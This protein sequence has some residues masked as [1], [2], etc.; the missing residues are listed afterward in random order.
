MS[1]IE[2]VEDGYVDVNVTNPN[3]EGGQTKQLDVYIVGHAAA[4][5]IRQYEA[6]GRPAGKWSEQAKELLAKYG[7]NVSA[8]TA[9]EICY[10]LINM[11][12]DQTKKSEATPQQE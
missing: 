1:C 12:G 4:A 3:G 11:L 2:V 8:K 6:E 9:D 5:L 7:V 10:R